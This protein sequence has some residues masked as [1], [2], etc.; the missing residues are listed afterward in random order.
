MKISLL[1]IISLLS[2]TCSE[3]EIQSNG[4]ASPDDMQTQHNLLFALYKKLQMND[5]LN[6]IH[7]VVHHFDGRYD[8]MWNLLTTKYGSAVQEVLESAQKLH[9]APDQEEPDQKE[10]PKG[11]PTINIV[12]PMTATQKKLKA[13]DAETY[14]WEEGG[15]PLSMQEQYAEMV[16]SS[17]YIQHPTFIYSNQKLLYTK[18]ILF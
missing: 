3:I 1:L 14:P 16:R 5:K 13:I 7:Q 15:K 12:N 2:A 9:H 17:A 4:G 6:S 8:E 11:T 10:M 18:F